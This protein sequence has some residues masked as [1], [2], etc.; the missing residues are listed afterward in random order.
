MKNW[1][2][3]SLQWSSRLPF[4][5]SREQSSSSGSLFTS[6]TIWEIAPLDLS[7]FEYQKSDTSCMIRWRSSFIAF[8]VPQVDV[9]CQKHEG[10]VPPYGYECLG[11]LQYI[12]RFREQVLQKTCS[13]YARAY[14]TCSSGSEVLC[15]SA[16]LLLPYLIELAAHVIE[17]VHFLILGNT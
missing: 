1:N 8:P 14:P 12:L 10:V 11:F 3:G 5:V 17:R 15:R 6:T 4:G 16:I 9:D 13:W 2:S 7:F